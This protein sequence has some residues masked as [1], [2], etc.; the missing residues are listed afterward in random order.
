MPNVLSLGFPCGDRRLWD[1]GCREQVV[2]LIITEGGTSR[3]WR[4]Q[5]LLMWQAYTQC[6]MVRNLAVFIVGL[7]AVHD[8]GGPEGK[9]VTRLRCMVRGACSTVGDRCFAVCRS[10]MRRLWYVDRGG[11][12]SQATIN[13]ACTCGLGR[14]AKV[15]VI[16]CLEAMH[17]KCGSEGQGGLGCWSVWGGNPRAMLAVASD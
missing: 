3:R 12:E 5:L 13:A 17:G 7:E 1:G 16:T 15:F 11:L 8:K 4:L 10:G 9:N 6:C 2:V 14:E